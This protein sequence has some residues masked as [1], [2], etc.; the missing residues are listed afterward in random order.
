MHPLHQLVRLNAASRRTRERNATR[1]YREID[2]EFF[3][4]GH[5]LPQPRSCGAVWSCTGVLLVFRSRATGSNFAGQESLMLSQSPSLL[6]PKQD[7]DRS[8]LSSSP[9]YTHKSTGSQ[10]DSKDRLLL[11]PYRSRQLAVTDLALAQ[12]YRIRCEK[13][14]DFITIC[15][16]NSAAASHYLRPDVE[17]TWRLA[18]HANISIRSTNE[19]NSLPM[20]RALLAMLVK[21]HARHGDLQTVT[22]LLA[23]FYSAV[24]SLLV[25]DLASQMGGYEDGGGGERPY[26]FASP[27]LEGILRL[28]VGDA[29]IPG[30]HSGL[31]WLA[32]AVR[33]YSECIFAWQLHE[34]KAELLNVLPL[35]FRSG[36]GASWLETWLASGSLRLVVKDNRKEERRD[37]GGARGR[38]RCA[39]CRV[40]VRGVVTTCVKC[41]HGGHLPHLR[42]WFA[43]YSKCPSGCNCPC[44]IACS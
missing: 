39:V 20:C 24:G 9:T 6:N 19:W 15:K 5:S 27:D 37:G 25:A 2:L 40:E 41:G 7:L 3:G 4:P 32:W 26:G 35:I 8:F 23:V 43:K 10:P 14:K 38:V 36:D 18:A 11:K 28:L 42:L 30:L 31:G 12:R 16:H 22:V 21:H 17:Q 13:V 33:T 34:V 29:E 1:G 44:Y